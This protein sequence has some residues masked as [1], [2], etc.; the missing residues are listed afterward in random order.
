MAWYAFW[1]HDSDRSSLDTLYL[2]LYVR[3][4]FN[5]GR[6]A[7]CLHLA[8]SIEFAR[9][10]TFLPVCIYYFA[11]LC[12]E[13]VPTYSPPKLSSPRSQLA[14]LPP[15]PFLSPLPLRFPSRMSEL[16]LIVAYPPLPSFLSRPRIALSVLHASKKEEEKKK[17]G[18]IHKH[19]LLA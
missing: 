3:G 5:G 7:Y 17:K 9:P 8:R 6:R 10:S 13:Y 1:L 19:F 2:Y 14:G 12:I 11:F 15:R 16:D 4:R 18:A